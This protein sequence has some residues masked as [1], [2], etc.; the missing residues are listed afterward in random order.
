MSNLLVDIKE[1]NIYKNTG[2][3]EIAKYNSIFPNYWND[4]RETIL[5]NFKDVYDNNISIY[6]P[7]NLPTYCIKKK[8]VKGEYK[9][10]KDYEDY[11]DNRKQ[12]LIDIT[13]TRY[14]DDEDFK[15]KVKERSRLYYDNLKK[16]KNEYEKIKK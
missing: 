14:K 15:I 10:K 4:N 9:Y 1:L 16:I 13:K 6:I 5:K 3:I 11:N 12:R 8:Y 7:D 2:L